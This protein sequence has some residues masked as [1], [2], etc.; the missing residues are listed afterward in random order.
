MEK[1]FCHKTGFTL[2]EV[3]MSMLLLGITGLAVFSVQISSMQ[4]I[5]RAAILTEAAALAS[6]E[7]EIFQIL[8]MDVFLNYGEKTT[9]G[10]WKKTKEVSGAGGQRIYTLYWNVIQDVPVSG[11]ARIAL[12]VHWKD[13]GQ[14]RRIFFEA[15][16]TGLL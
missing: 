14:E 2:V 5:N 15:L 13:R 3:L 6:Q 4:A 1:C 12:E 10:E 7:L 8:P 16:K 9:G 11:M